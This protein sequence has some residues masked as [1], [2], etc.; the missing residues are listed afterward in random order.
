M[1]RNDLVNS[2]LIGG[3][4]VEY[5][6]KDIAPIVYGNC[7]KCHN[8]NG[9][10]PFSLTSFENIKKRAK[11]IAFVTVNRMMPPWPADPNYTHFVGESLLSQNQINLIH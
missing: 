4:F 1:F 6:I 5:R 10:A 9:I 3:A 11:T 8:P 2:I 7:T